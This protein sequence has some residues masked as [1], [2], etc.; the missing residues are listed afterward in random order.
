MINW[1]S[2]LVRWIRERFWLFGCRVL[3]R[4]RRSQKMRRRS[5]RITSASVFEKVSLP[6]PVPRRIWIYWDTGESTAPDI[7]RFCIV[8]WRDLHP[9]WQ[10]EVLDRGGAE[11]I[12]N[13]TDMPEGMRPAHYA[14][15]LRLRLL[16]QYGGVWADATYLPVRG[17]DAWLPPLMQSGFFAFGVHV[18][19]R[20]LSNWFLASETGGTVVTRWEESARLYWKGRSEPHAYFWTHYLFEWLVRTDGEVRQCWR[21]TPR[22]HAAAAL[23]LKRAL[24]G[25]WDESSTLACLRESG[26]DAVPVHKLDWKKGSLEYLETLLIKLA[27]GDTA[28][29]STPADDED[30]R[31]GKSF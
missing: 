26:P 22:V 3:M 18:A 14:D 8:R 4:A 16:K 7:V 27:S 13:M 24:I 17:L 28:R 2:G 1:L 30:S 20:I 9:D 19:D 31:S 6:R 21:D 15:I 11:A 23:L 25:R 12:V 29:E 5:R 10:V